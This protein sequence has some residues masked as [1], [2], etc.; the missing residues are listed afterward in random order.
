MQPDA[1]GLTG[2]S[3]SRYFR[4]LDMNYTL[5]SSISIND[6]LQNKVSSMTFV[7]QRNEEITYKYFRQ[8]FDSRNMNFVVWIFCLL[9]VSIYEETHTNWWREITLERFS[10]MLIWNNAYNS[11]MFTTNGRD[12]SVSH[13]V[14]KLATKV[15][16]WWG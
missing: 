11:L 7:H 6:S 2:E 10:A 8:N 13:N 9:S 14:C 12:I 1:I 5:I 16:C 15:P 4:I 3:S